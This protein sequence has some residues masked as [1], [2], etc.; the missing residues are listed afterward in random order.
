MSI[1]FNSNQLKSIKEGHSILNEAYFGESKELKEV[2][3][4]FCKLRSIY[5]GE[6]KYFSNINT[7]PE[8]IKF[9]RMMEDFFGFNTFALS[10]DQSTIYNAYTVPISFA[11]DTPMGSKIVETTKNGYRIKDK[12]KLNVICV[13]HTSIFVDDEFTDREVFAVLLHEVGHNFTETMSS[14]PTFTGLYMKS[15]GLINCI[16]GVLTLDIKSAASVS[17]P[18]REWYEETVQRI[19]EDNPELTD[20]FYFLKGCKAGLESIIINGID[21]LNIGTVIINPI[22]ALISSVYNRLRSFLQSPVM[23]LRAIVGYND[24]KISDNFA[25][26]YGFG[27]DLSSALNKFEENGAGLA[28]RKVVGNIP[29]LGHLYD[30]FSLP[31]NRILSYFDEHPSTPSRCDAQLRYLKNELKN[32]KLDPKMKKQILSDISDIEEEIKRMYKDID[33]DDTKAFSKAYGGIL[34]SL[35][36]GDL[37]EYIY[38]DNNKR[39]DDLIRKTRIY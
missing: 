38:K 29:I 12:Y 10:F 33:S 27:A 14:V 9:N 11:I 31:I 22:G 5:I 25:T 21:V 19:R 3:D 15:L 2:F 7:D 34:I 37:R 24:E 26:V 17:N 36:G 28:S 8:L 20:A 30:I 6:S 18:T 35:C 39:F 23:I 16:Y 1:F 4:Q 32:E 13:L